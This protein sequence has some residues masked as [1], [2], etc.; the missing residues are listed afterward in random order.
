MPDIRV[1]ETFE[2]D[3]WQVV[4]IP[5]LGVNVA[6]REETVRVRGLGLISYEGNLPAQKLSPTVFMREDF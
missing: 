5:F 2:K 1:V 6:V 3:G 4:C